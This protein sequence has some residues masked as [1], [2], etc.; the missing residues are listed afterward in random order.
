M[1]SQFPLCG[2]AITAPLP[3]ARAASRFSTPVIDWATLRL[4]SLWSIEGSRNISCQ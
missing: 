2:S 4:T 1:A 3:S